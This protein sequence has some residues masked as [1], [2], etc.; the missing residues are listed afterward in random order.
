MQRRSLLCSSIAL[1]AS[2]ATTRAQL[3][4]DLGVGTTL[5]PASPDQGFH[6]PYLLWVPPV[7]TPPILPFLLVEPNNSGHV[8]LKFNDH[9]LSAVE[10]AQQGLGG[11]VARI[12]SVPLLMPVFPR[13]P[14]L[15]THSLGR[16]TMLTTERTLRRLDLQLLAM[17]RD[18][19]PRLVSYG[20]SVNDQVILTGF[21]ASAMFVTRFTILHPRAVRAVAAGGLNGFVI[22]PVPKLNTI[23]LQYPL[24]IADLSTFT[25]QI[26]PK[27][28]WNNIPQFLFMGATD[29]ND[30]VPYD[31]AW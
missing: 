22:L 5:I 7:N 9:L 15:Y 6:F 11:N 28:A 14:G 24:G 29:T 10:T 2:G 21:S 26:F 31:D 30:A 20:L 12:L 18:A 23:T 13:N 16:Q 4:V 27:A 19:R 25:G 17:I 8:S 3:F 1:L